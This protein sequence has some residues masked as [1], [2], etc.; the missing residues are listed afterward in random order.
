[1]PK[2]VWSYNTTVHR[3]TN[4]MPFWLMYRADT[5]L[6]QEFKYRSLQTATEAPACPS[7]AKGKDVL[8]SDRLKVVTNLEKYHEETKAWR[9]PRVKLQELDVGNMVLL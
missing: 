1:M 5:V 9:D 6:P 2:A 7:E 8:E 4:F 3:A